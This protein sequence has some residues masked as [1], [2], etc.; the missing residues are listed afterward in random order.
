MKSKSF[1]DL[2]SIG[3]YMYQS[4]A[5]PQFIHSR[6]STIARDL[7]N[8]QKI[9]RISPLPQE[10]FSQISANVIYPIPTFTTN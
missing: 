2:E 6:P 3:S 1:N 4:G 7:S 5:V 9:R 8:D 10:R